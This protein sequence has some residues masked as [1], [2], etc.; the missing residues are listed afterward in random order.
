MAS[1]GGTPR[2][3]LIVNADDLGLAPSVNA[4]IEDAALAGVVTSAS[5]IVN[6]GGFDDA[7]RRAAALRTGL[8]V[9]LHFNLTLG[10][11]VS[12]AGTV[13]SLVDGAGRFLT[14]GRVIRRALAGRLRAGDV[15][16]EAD[17]QL[18]RLTSSGLRVIHADSHH[19]VHA[20]PVVRG[21]L[22]A[23]A[24]S[25]GVSWVR[26]PVEPLLARPTGLLPVMR[27]AALALAWM[28]SGRPAAPA[29]TTAFRGLALRGGARFQS[30]L[31]ELLDR[32]PPGLTELMV[33]P[34][35][36]DASLARLDSYAGE[37]AAEL[38]ALLSVSV[39]ERLGRGDLELAGFGG[40]Q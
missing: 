14:L 31:L 27:R 7:V 5:M 19:H 39:R 18:A 34:G 36:A 26:R 38:A 40:A 32:L 8:D 37:R 13:P 2:R 3:L 9:G 12:P 20:L 23:A 4:G 17:A 30:S 33:H 24:L 22:A 6:M 28:A 10:A 35:R 15:R 16:R 11:P 1:G 25:A 29:G 21:A